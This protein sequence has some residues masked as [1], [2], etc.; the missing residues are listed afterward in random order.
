MVVELKNIVQK[1]DNGKVIFDNFSLSIEDKPDKGQ[2]VALMGESGCGKSTV[3][4]YITGLQ[5]PTSGVVLVNGK[6]VGEDHHIP[7]VFQERSALPFYTVVHNVAL[8]LLL[9][10]V[11]KSEAYDRA[12][13]MLEIVG[14]KGQEKKWAQ[15]PSL[16]G[17]QLQRVAIARSLVANPTFLVLD[18]PFSSLDSAT[19]KSMQDFL[20]RLFTDSE[21]A[22]LNP[23]FIIVT[24]DEREAIYLANDIYVLKA[25]PGQV[26]QHIQVEPMDRKSMQFA[27][28]VVQLE[29]I[30]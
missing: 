6:E 18:E 11:A 19:R 24:H 15:Y 21:L 5:K 10:K 17:G 27:Q 8:P 3:L 26:K 23:S 14:L 7:M 16:S 20:K 30:I 22:D 4:R 13:K 12:E 29:E 25:N 9:S 28:A 2:F 1:Y